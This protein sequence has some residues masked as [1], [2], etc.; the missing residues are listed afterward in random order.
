MRFLGWE[1]GVAPPS[2]RNLFDDFCDS[3]VFGMRQ[4]RRPRFSSETD[5]CPSIAGNQNLDST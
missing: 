3:S 4:V 1:E 5:P 2:L